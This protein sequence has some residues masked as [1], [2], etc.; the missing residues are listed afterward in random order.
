MLAHRV[1][2]S[3]FEHRIG[4]SREQRFRADHVLDAEPARERCGGRVGAAPGKRDDLDAGQAASPRLFQYE[5]GNGA[6]AEQSNTQGLFHGSIIGST[7]EM[8]R[9]ESR[10]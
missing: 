3:C 5:P 10:F 8:A 4:A 6:A 9:C 2:R 1:V 7:E